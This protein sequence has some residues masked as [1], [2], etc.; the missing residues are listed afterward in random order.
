MSELTTHRVII[1]I[2]TVNSSHT[3]D[4]RCNAAIPAKSSSRKSFLRYLHPFDK[5]ATYT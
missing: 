4:I 1:S 2:S 5:L 3:N